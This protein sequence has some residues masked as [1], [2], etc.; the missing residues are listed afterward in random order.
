M[1]EKIQ[2]DWID[3]KKIPKPKFTEKSQLWEILVPTKRNNGKPISTR[4]HRIWDQKI[5]NIAGGLTVLKPA[6]GQWVSPDGELF[7]ERMI[8]VR[9]ACSEEQ[10]NEISDFTAKYYEQKAVMISL[11]STDV[12]IKHY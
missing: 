11:V 1:V 8:P 10:A 12:R 4:F 7:H 6:I 2:L 3:M 5:R 9:I